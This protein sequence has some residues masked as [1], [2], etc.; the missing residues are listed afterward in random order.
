[1]PTSWFVLCAKGDVSRG[2]IGNQLG[3]VCNRIDTRHRHR[4]RH[5]GNVYHLRR[6]EHARN[7]TQESFYDRG[8]Q[9]RRG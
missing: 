4:P 8:W 5:D 2:E 7:T 9:R 6:P 3:L 1:M